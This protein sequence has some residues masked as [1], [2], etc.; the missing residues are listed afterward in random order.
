MLS[1]AV[2]ETF[3]VHSRWPSA[4]GGA[5]AYM[6]LIRVCGSHSTDAQR[7]CNAR[8]SAACRQSWTVDEDKIKANTRI[9][10]WLRSTRER[11][12]LKLQV[13]RCYQMLYDCVTLAARSQS[14]VQRCGPAVQASSVVR[15]HHIHM[16]TVN[17]VTSCSVTQ[18][19]P[20]NLYAKHA[21]PK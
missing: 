17:I 14:R 13:N 8:L 1:I 3:A 7:L 6:C 12:T 10:T 19:H 20:M 11:W 15:R 21:N 4:I 18:C 16:V 2:L 9:W 5:C